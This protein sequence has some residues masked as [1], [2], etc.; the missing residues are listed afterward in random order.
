MRHYADAP[1]DSNDSGGDDD[2]GLR[3]GIGTSSWRGVWRGI[4]GGVWGGV[5]RVGVAAPNDVRGV[6][7]AA[8]AWGFKSK[9][10]GKFV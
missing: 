9:W 7:V 8:L 1:L 6:S 4:G 5:R 2:V 3:S 10:N